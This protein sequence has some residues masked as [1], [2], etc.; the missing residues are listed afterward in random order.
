MAR[1]VVMNARKG[2]IDKGLGGN[3][4]KTDVV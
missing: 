3:L 4:A 2:I 1:K